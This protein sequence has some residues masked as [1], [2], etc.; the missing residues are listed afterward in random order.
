MLCISF[1]IKNYSNPQKN[2]L[3][4]YR[5]LYYSL[6]KSNTRM[7]MANENLKKLGTRIGNIDDLPDF[8][9]KE[10]T[11]FSI[12]GIEEQIYSVL[13]DD[14]DGF[15]TL[16]EIMVLLYRKYGIQDKTRKDL[17]TL[18]YKLIR[19]K[20][21]QKVAGKKSAY[22]LYGLPIEEEEGVKESDIQS[23]E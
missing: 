18:V 13:K 22:K 14:L 20:M 19:R 3:V 10:I 12:E 21:V 16:S 5:E 1:K 2:N 11:E 8:L 6:T 15:G 7:N 17:T 9:K 4:F 23:G